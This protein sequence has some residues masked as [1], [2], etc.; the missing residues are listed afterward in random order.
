[1]QHNVCHVEQRRPDTHIPTHVCFDDS[2]MCAHLQKRVCLPVCLLSSLSDLILNMVSD[3]LEG[4]VPSKEALLL[5]RSCILSARDDTQ[6][7]TP[8]NL[9]NQLHAMMEPEIEEALLYQ[10]FGVSRL[11]QSVTAEEQGDVAGCAPAHALAKDGGRRCELVP[12][13][14][15]IYT[16]ICVDVEHGENNLPMYAP[17]AMPVLSCAV[18]ACS[19]P[20]HAAAPGEARTGSH[21][22]SLRAAL[23]VLAC[24]ASPLDGGLTGVSR[25]DML[26]CQP[27]EHHVK[28]SLM[29]SMCIQIVCAHA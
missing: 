29:S 11:A 12:C 23:S 27:I 28:N 21:F 24:D 14:I 2:P 6:L 26:L 8:L 16:H 19:A 3:M 9:D 25:S 22:S 13:I 5:V 15:C 7:Y 4:Q 10:L 1:M 17:P 18:C 20:S